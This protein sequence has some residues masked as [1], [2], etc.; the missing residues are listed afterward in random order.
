MLRNGKVCALVTVDLFNEGI[1]LPEVDTLLLLRPTQSPVVFQQQIGRG[2]RL[3]PGKESCLILDFVGRHRA[4]FRFDRLFTP[5]TG[6]SPDGNWSDRSR[7]AFR[8]FQ[9]AAI[10][11]L[12]DSRVNKF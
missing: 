6:L 1:D 3:A 12:D 9:Q 7:M 2:H 8:S 10:S 4:E 5:L 11:N